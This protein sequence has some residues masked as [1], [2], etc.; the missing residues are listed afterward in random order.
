MY[1]RKVIFISESEHMS[2]VNDSCIQITNKNEYCLLL[3]EKSDCY[4]KRFKDSREF[5][6]RKSYP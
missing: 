6:K 4:N 3:A 5:R 2:F 1:T